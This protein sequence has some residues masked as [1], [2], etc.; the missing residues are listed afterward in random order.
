MNRSGWWPRILVIVGLVNMVAG[1][2][3]PMEGAIIILAGSGL[4]A[5]GARVGKSRHMK[6]VRWSFALTVI[7]VAVFWVLS[8]RGGLGGDT[9]RS[10]W[11]ALI[12]LPYPVG[13]VMSIIAAVRVLREYSR[14]AAPSGAE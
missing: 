4:A 9:F 1:L 6:F 11:W 5:L 12:V 14:S 13:W 2:L 3:D 8:A 10:M 7:G